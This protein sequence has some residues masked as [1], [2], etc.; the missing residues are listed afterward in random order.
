MGK[1]PT[2]VN[3]R[4]YRSAKRHGHNDEKLSGLR[5]VGR[6][7]LFW[8]YE[9]ITEIDSTVD[10]PYASFRARSQGTKKNENLAL[11]FM[12]VNQI[13][14]VID[15]LTELKK[16]FVETHHTCPKCGHPV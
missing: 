11:H 8:V 12:S 16:K 2:H 6:N 10:Q 5:G 9:F 14:D 15:M 7:G 4:I 13:D 1:D 3:R